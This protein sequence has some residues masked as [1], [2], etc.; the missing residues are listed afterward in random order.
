[1]AALPLLTAAP[2]KKRILILGG[3]GYL[4]PATVNA[5]TARGHVLTL[6]NRGRT[7]PG[8]FPNIE[9]L[10]GDRDPD[11][12]EGLNALRNHKWD[13]VIDNS[14]GVPR[15]VAA[16]AKLLAP[17]V[18][19]Y[20]YISSISAYADNSLEGQDETAKLATTPDPTVETVTNQTFGPLK[21][22]CEKAAAEA[23]P[24]R[25]TIVRPGFIVGPDDPSGR[26]T[27]WPV[28]IDRGGEVF[29]PGAPSDPVQIIDVRDLG[30]WLITLVEQETT[31]TFNACGPKDRLPWGDLLEACR[32]ATKTS[33]SLTWV[34]ADW[35]RRE[36]R[37][38]FPIWVPYM[39]QTRGFHMW[40]NERAVKAGLRFRPAA[41][42]VA[43]TLRWYKGQKEGDRTKLAGPT[44]ERESELL[45]KW[46]EKP[47]N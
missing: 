42:T 30:A 1:M 37:G 26:F 19:Q 29:A 16:S 40:K 8:L 36:G 22:L 34:P 6:F 46:K 21:V 45:A 20:I 39:D 47:G 9:T 12:D 18:G 11:K 31:G 14:G 43:D 4:G 10:T 33:N 44:P 23:F 38:A 5:A 13:A 32:K 25:V 2:V 24:G 3:T 7:R 28:R 35:L 27:Y 17:N 15:H 41:E